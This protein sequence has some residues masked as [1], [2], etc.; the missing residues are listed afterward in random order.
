V[1]SRTTLAII[2]GILVVCTGAFT[3]ILL[4]NQANLIPSN[5]T[6]TSTTTSPIVQTALSVIVGNNTEDYTI[7]EIM[8]LPATTGEGGYMKSTGTIVGPFNYT[9]VEIKT[10]LE[11]VGELPEGYSVEVK[12]K[13]G[14]TSYY[15]RANV[16]G[17]FSG[18]TPTKEP[19]SRIEC[20]LILAYHINGSPLAND[21]GPLRLVMLNVDGNLTDGHLWSRQV[22]SIRV[23][24]EVDTWELH[25]DGV[26]TWNITHDT[27]YALASWDS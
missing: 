20:T 16:E 11:E 7:E 8:N 4:Y 1:R 22:V 27:Y 9:G 21:I 5:T 18:Y 13:D 17:V 26:E 6:S 19:L 10:L 12:S 3:F 2:I 24:N 15:T 25:L 14:W 23:I